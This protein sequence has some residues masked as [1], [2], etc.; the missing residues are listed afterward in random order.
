MVELQNIAMQHGSQV[1]F[2]DTGFKVNPG[3][4]VGL[5]GANGSGKTT[6][7]RLIVGE[8][9]PDDGTIERPKKLTIAYFRQDFAEW[10]ERSVLEETMAGAS[11]LTALGRELAELEARLGDVD[12]PDHERVIDR[13]SEVQASYSALGGYTIEPRAR[14]LL[15]GLGFADAEVDGPIGALSG[16]WRMRVQLARILLSQAELLLLDEPTNY[17]D[18]ESILWLEEW[19]RDY[20]GAVLMTCHDRDVMNRVVDKIVEIDGGKIRTYTGD[21]DAY[22]AARAL[23]AA[24][25]QAEYDKQQAMLQKDLRFI[26]RFKAQPSRA[27]AVQSR[28]KKLEKVERLEPPKRIVEK[29]FNFRRPSRGS[30]DVVALQG[31]SK[32]FGSRVVHRRVD[33]VV[34]RAE[35]WAIMGENG[36]GKTTLLKM[37]AGALAP[38]EGKVVLGTSTELGYFAQHQMEQLELEHTI[39][40]ELQA[41]APQEG[42]GVLRNVAGAFGFS[43]DDVDKPVSV[44]SGGERAR[45]ALAKMLYDAPNLLVLDEPTNHLDLTTKKALVRALQAYDGTLV[46]VSHDRAFLRALATRVVELAPD[47]PHMF[48]GTYDEYVVATGHEAPGLRQ[49]A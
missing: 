15:A 42:I 31:V 12:A 5:V 30:N 16:G 29:D 41:H 10:G 43:G 49:Q 47:G 11:Q 44:L 13:Y 1:L 39:L 14:S 8:E 33:L 35:R 6:V 20:G 19:L 32:A 25:R 45:L 22:E 36:R 3:E 27:S 28:A 37:M 26:A 24:Q 7:F 9:R 17:L 23:D 48:H 34:R 2:V 40:E 46:F 18:I 4:K 38:D 21:F